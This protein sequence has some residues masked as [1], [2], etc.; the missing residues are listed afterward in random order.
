MAKAIAFLLLLLIAP[1]AYAQ[2]TH[3]VGGP[4]GWNT[5][6]NYDS[7]ARGQTFATGD[8]LVFNYDSSHAVDEVNQADYQSCN[9]GNAINSSSSSPTTISLSNAGTRYFICPRSN[10]CSQGMKLAVTV[11]GGSTSPSGSPPNSGGSN[12][13]PP[14]TPPRTPPPPAGGATSI[15]GGRS[16]LMVG[17]SVILGALL[18]LMG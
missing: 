7:W 4:S 2:T 18:G 6:I 8:T 12:P 16:S 15:L 13:S 10:H 3:T 14:G 5:G 1:A 17:I 11:S 9:N